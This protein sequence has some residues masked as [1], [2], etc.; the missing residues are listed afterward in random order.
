MKSLRLFFGPVLGLKLLDGPLRRS[1]SLGDPKKS[2]GTLNSLSESPLGSGS[3]SMSRFSVADCVT[4][5]SKQTVLPPRIWNGLIYLQVGPRLASLF[6]SCGLRVSSTLALPGF[7][8]LGEFAGVCGLLLRC[9]PL[10]SFAASLQ[11]SAKP[12]ALRELLTMSISCLFAL[13][14]DYLFTTVHCVWPLTYW[15]T[16]FPRR[17]I[18]LVDILLI[19]WTCTKVMYQRCGSRPLSVASSVFHFYI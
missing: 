11:L 6:L 17:Y 19:I 18:R 7:S 14:I 4:L 13:D 10:L 3:E 2:K 1:S 9:G 8:F 15:S 12:F 5:N 16:G